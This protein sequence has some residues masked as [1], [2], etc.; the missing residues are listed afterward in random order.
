MVAE[1]G[2]LRKSGAQA[3]PRGWKRRGRVLCLCRYCHGCS[4]SRSLPLEVE[5][6]VI[7]RW[8]ALNTGL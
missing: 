4:V 6:L 5:N 3:S 8:K 7:G 2:G 1:L